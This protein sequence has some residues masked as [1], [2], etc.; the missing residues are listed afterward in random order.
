MHQ[1][2]TEENYDE[3]VNTMAFLVGC[4]FTL[5]A[6]LGIGQIAG[7][8]SYPVLVGFAAGASLVIGS[9]QVKHIFLVESDDSGHPG[10]L[11]NM[12][13]LKNLGDA[14]AAATIF[15]FITLILLQVSSLS[16]SL[17][18]AGKKSESSE[19][20]EGVSFLL[21]LSLTISMCCFPGVVSLPLS[22][23]QKC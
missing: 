14:N 2:Q 4:V 16:L 18:L 1:F 15:G 11:Q 7:F 19:K 9:S 6:V 3:Y 13:A 12:S 8:F 5:F 22:L 23:S 21:S 17:S 10:F 20:R